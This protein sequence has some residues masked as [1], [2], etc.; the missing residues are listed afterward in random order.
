MLTTLLMK[1]F[2]NKNRPKLC[3]LKLNHLMLKPFKKNSKQK[4]QSETHGTVITIETVKVNQ[5]RLIELSKSYRRDAEK[6]NHLVTL[7]LFIAFSQPV[8]D[9]S[10]I[11]NT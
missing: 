5:K 1:C 4:E 8:I 2:R 10:F 9:D 6:P 11:D 3:Y 7:F